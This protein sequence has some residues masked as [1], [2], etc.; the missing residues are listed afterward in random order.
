MAR[1]LVSISPAAG[2][3]GNAALRD[4]L[5]V[6][7]ESALRERGFA[8]DF[9][10]AGSADE[11]QRLVRHAHDDGYELVVMAGGDG[12]VRLGVN[13]IAGKHV[14]MGIVPLGTGNLL[15]A[16]LGIPRDPM[17]AAE[18]L[19]TASPVTIDTGLLKLDGQSER[20]AVAAGMGF[21]ARV[22]AATSPAAK[23]RFGVLADFATVMRLVA[24]LPVAQ[25]EIVVDGRTYELPTVAVL[26]ANCGQVVPGLLGPRAM[27]D[28]SDGV[29]DVIAIRGGPWLTKL[30]IAARSA[31]HS[32]F[33]TDT[34]M[35]G[36]SLRLRGRHITVRTDP[37][38]PIQI[39]GDL[40]ASSS[41]AFRAA[42][43]PRSLTV[44]V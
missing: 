24:S 41:G 27:L 11:A 17:L 1:A 44:L 5:V 43:R 18:R 10:H 14:P 31:L 39:D 3:G 2:R 26:V 15:A 28:P 8:S 25:A 13:A 29:L 33:R 22:M 4:R 12:T 6:A 32:L 36:E 23:A 40:L 34:E 16:A 37:P 21:D 20:F 30:P 38:E 42:I 35:G 9:L 19:A 7:I